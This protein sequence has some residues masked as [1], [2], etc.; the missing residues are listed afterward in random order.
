MVPGQTEFNLLNSSD[1][2]CLKY[3]TPS[4]FSNSLSFL[5]FF[6]KV[7]S[8]YWLLII[9]LCSIKKNLVDSCLYIHGYKQELLS[10]RIR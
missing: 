3:F 5:C 8:G 4:H 10:H 9:K 6:S 2:I 1:A 7:H